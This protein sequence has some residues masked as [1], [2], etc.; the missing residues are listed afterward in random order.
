MYR[1][2]RKP[3]LPQQFCVILAIYAFGQCTVW[4]TVLHLTHHS[5]TILLFKLLLQKTRKNKNKQTNK[6]TETET[7]T[8]KTKKR[9]CGPWATL[10]WEFCNLMWNPKRYFTSDK[11]NPLSIYFGKQTGKLKNDFTRVSKAGL[12]FDFK[13]QYRSIYATFGSVFVCYCF[14]NGIIITHRQYSVKTCWIKKTKLV[15]LRQKSS[16]KTS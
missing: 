7:K 11:S 2:D 10:D 14:T 13:L 3:F 5:W 4:T 12:F 6:K 1:N 15:N 8:K 9:F 16:L